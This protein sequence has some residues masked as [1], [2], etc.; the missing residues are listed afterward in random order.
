ME[1]N[2]F[3]EEVFI[4]DPEIQ[5]HAADLVVEVVQKIKDQE[6]VLRGMTFRALR[7]YLVEVADEHDGSIPV[8]DMHRIFDAVL[9][10]DK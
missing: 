10:G 8:Q 6:R 3:R 9:R 1:D 5:K 2:I 7:E 4:N